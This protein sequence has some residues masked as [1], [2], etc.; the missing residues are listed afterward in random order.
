MIQKPG[1]KTINLRNVFTADRGNTTG[2]KYSVQTVGRLESIT[3]LGSVFVPRLTILFLSPYHRRFT[4][5][6]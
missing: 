3:Y 2:F 5:Y 6:V 4:T 1:E